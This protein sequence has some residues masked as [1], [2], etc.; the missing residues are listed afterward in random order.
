[1]LTRRA[2][3]SFAFHVY[4]LFR[5]FLKTA[6]FFSFDNYCGIRCPESCPGN[7]SEL[8]KVNLKRHKWPRRNTSNLMEHPSSEEA[9][10]HLEYAAPAPAPTSSAPRLPNAASAHL[11]FRLVIT[12][13]LWK[14]RGFV[15]GGNLAG[16]GTT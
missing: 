12:I 8:I 5:I 7:S 15:D 11:E 13:C 16:V 2:E 3:L 10:F 1:M 9:E 6:A 4:N 14:L